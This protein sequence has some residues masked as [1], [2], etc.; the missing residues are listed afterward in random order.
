M[1]SNKTSR[2]TGES[3]EETREYHERY[4][5]VVNCP[6]RKAILKAPKESCTTIEEI[7]KSPFYKFN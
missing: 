6:V 4:L 7:I 3:I 2:T 1:A 5:R